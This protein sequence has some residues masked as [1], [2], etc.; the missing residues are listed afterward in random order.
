MTSS[1]TTTPTPAAATDLDLSVLARMVDNDP[2]RFRKFARLFLASV[3]DVLAQLD[4]AVLRADLDAM[5][6]L[7]HRAKSTSMN[8]G[9]SGFSRQCQLLEST[10]RQGDAVAAQACARG[11]RPL[12]QGI[13]S[14]IEQRLG[15]LGREANPRSGA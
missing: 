2:V 13:R 4:D 14:A 5:A 11:L 6:G 7:G 9:A 10:A 15:D 3:E 12:L 1:S 8:I